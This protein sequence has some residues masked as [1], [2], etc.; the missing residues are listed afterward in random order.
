MKSINT[1]LST[2]IVTGTGGSLVLLVGN[3]DSEPCE[4]ATEENL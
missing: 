1:L 3:D 4:K 2:G